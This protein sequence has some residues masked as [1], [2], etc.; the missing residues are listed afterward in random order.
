MHSPLF[1]MV[2]HLVDIP[3][4]NVD[5]DEHGGGGGGSKKNKAIRPYLRV[6]KFKNVR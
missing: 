1:I 3:A 4:D 2:I 6:D 5:S